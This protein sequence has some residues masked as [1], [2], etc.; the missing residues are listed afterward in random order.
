M[1]RRIRYADRQKQ[2]AN[3]TEYVSRLKATDAIPG[4]GLNLDVPATA[5]KQEASLALPAGPAAEL[6]SVS[7]S[8]YSPVS[9]PGETLRV[10]QWDVY[11]ILNN[12]CMASAVE[13]KYA[14]QKSGS[15]VLALCTCEY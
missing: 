11:G 8:H 12:L 3:D 2:P 1:D 10:P 15:S 7:Q 9:K 13:W 4:V 6:M 5:A 14:I